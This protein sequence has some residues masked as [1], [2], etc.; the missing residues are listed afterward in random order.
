MHAE[1]AH[2][3]VCRKKCFIL[4]VH[5]SH[6]NSLASI[7]TY[8]WTLKTLP[9]ILSFERQDIEGIADMSSLVSWHFMTRLY[10]CKEHPLIGKYPLVERRMVVQYDTIEGKNVVTGNLFCL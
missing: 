4:Y 3:G 7:N 2:Y 8:V 5:I 1:R 6:V 9:G 10:K